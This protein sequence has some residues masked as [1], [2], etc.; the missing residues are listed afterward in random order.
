MNDGTYRMV[1]TSP[2]YVQYYPPPTP[3]ITLAHTEWSKHHQSM[4]VHYPPPYLMNHIPSNSIP[5]QA[6][7][8]AMMQTHPHY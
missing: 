1:Q 5:T 8:L 7:M 4:H 6:N 2:E 3:I